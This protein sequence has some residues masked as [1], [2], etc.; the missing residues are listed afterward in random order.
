MR[1]RGQLRDQRGLDEL[2]ARD[3]HG[4]LRVDERGLGDE[5]RRECRLDEVLALADE[6]PR[7][8]ALV[9]RDEPAHELHPC[10]DTHSPWKSRCPT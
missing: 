9:T 3:L 10:H 8:L 1:E 4:P 5:A 2:R 7:A 6:E